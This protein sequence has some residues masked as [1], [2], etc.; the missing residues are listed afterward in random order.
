[1]SEIP[2]DVVRLLDDAMYCVVVKNQEEVSAAYAEAEKR[3]LRI[4]AQSNTGLPHGVWRL[5]F[6]NQK[7]FKKSGEWKLDPRRTEIAK[8]FWDWN[9]SRRHGGE[10]DGLETEGLMARQL[11]HDFAE[12]VIRYLD[13]F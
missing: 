12:A 10:W 8:M 4:A 13:G 2:E 5:T 9:G 7:A 3:G 11:A 6:L 1:M